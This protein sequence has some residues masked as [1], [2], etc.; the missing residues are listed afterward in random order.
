MRRRTT[1]AM[2]ALA[3]AAVW[4]AAAAPQRMGR[5]PGPPGMRGPGYR[6]FPGPARKAAGQNLVE[7]LMSMSPEEQQ[8]FMRN[9]PRFQ[10]LPS[11]QQE[12]I[13]R[14]LE[15]FNKLPPTQRETLRER[16]ELF[17]QLS[18][19][20]QDRARALYRQW[21]EQP[22]GRRRELRQE[23]QHLREATPEERKLRLESPEFRAR[24]SEAERDLLR[25][26]VDL[27]N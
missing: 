8:E 2:A 17:Q 13:Q 6:P 7:H 26:L 20:Q 27:E 14:R 12:N 4:T 5:Y 1:W 25:G 24:F 18:P 10:H 15:E 21:H 22:A 19:E 11:R 16:Y 9:D 23:F 3:L